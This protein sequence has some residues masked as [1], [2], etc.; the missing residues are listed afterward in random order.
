MRPNFK[1]QSNACSQT[2]FS[3]SDVRCELPDT[4][5]QRCQQTL[6]HVAVAAAFVALA[7]V[8]RVIAHVDNEVRR[9]PCTH[10]RVPISTRPTRDALCLGR[11]RCG[12]RSRD[13]VPRAR[14]ITHMHCTR[15]A[16]CSAPMEHATVGTAPSQRLR[17]TYRWH[18]RRTRW[19][20]CSTR[21]RPC[22]H[23]CPRR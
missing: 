21:I 10:G 7:F 17:R 13:T 4:Q 9:R 12:W 23:R 11:T 6:V 1:Q 14:S 15:T 18:S 8:V 5:A 3:A 19:P 2:T 22:R 20:C 16:P